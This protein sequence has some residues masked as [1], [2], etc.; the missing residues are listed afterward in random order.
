M[1]VGEI[2]L[3]SVLT[4]IGSVFT[5]MIGYVGSVCE[6]IVGNPLLLIGFCIPFAF[7]I[8]HFVKKMF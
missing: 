2:T 8:V 5:S 3:A 7:A 6:T 4:D 1:V